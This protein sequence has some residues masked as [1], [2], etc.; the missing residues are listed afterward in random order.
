MERPDDQVR[1]ASTSVPAT[2]TGTTPEPSVPELKAEIAQ[3]REEM[4]ETIAA[5]Q[6]RLSPSHLA[7]QAKSTVREATIG[8]V[9]NMAEGA[10]QTASDVATQTRRAA[11]RLPR[12]VRDNPLPFALIG[13]GVVWLLARTRSQSNGWDDEELRDEYEPGYGYD[14]RFATY[15][16]ADSR[17]SR[18]ATSDVSD[19]ISD[20]ASSVG[21][22]A[23]DAGRRAR[24][25]GRDMASNVGDMASTASRRARELG[26]D[27]TSNVSDM[28][29]N[30]GRRAREIGRETQ[31]TISR[32]MDDNPLAL[33]AAALVAGAIFG[34]ML[35][36]TEVEDSYLGETRDSVLDSAREMAEDK[37]QQ[38]ADTVRESGEH[39][40]TSPS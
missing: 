3:T 4:Q 7:E 29:S 30:V 17:R 5:I 8:R 25:I 28:A 23:S 11:R 31:S 24:D 9:A 37:V 32:T 21:D 38:L 2:D 27:M 14:S 10:R 26:N 35:P 19:R 39:G 40:R 16:E 20:M 1:P 6:A 18:S 34:M 15:E 33:G 36:R 12:P 13:A 22:M